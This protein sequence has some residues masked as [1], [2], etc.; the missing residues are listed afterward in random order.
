MAHAEIIAAYFLAGQLL[1]WHLNENPEKYL[2]V[3]FNLKVEHSMHLICGSQSWKV[4]QTKTELQAF[5]WGGDTF[6]IGQYTN[7]SPD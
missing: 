7:T 5:P 6:Q 1:H 4:D 3:H 2:V